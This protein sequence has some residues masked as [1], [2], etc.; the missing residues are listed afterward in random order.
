MTGIYGFLIPDSRF[1]ASRAEAGD[2][3]RRLPSEAPIPQ[4]SR[5]AAKRVSSRKI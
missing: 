2:Y 3:R 5:P 1:E 4:T